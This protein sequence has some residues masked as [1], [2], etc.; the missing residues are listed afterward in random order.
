[1]TIAASTMDIV[2]Q[3]IR[4]LFEMDQPAML[5]GPPGA[6]KTDVIGQLAQAVDAD[7]TTAQLSQ[8]GDVDLRGV[9]HVIEGL[10]HWARPA[11]WP[12]DPNRRHILFLDEFDR[13]HTSVA[14]AALQIILHRRIGEHALPANTYVC[15]AGN[16]STD[17]IGTNKLS[18]ANA[19]RLSHLYCRPSVPAWCD[20]ATGAAIDPVLVAFAR[21]R[22]VDDKGRDLFETA[23]KPLDGEHAFLSPRTLT[24]CAPMLRLPAAQRARLIRG[25][26][27]SA[28]GNELVA[29]ADMVD[30]L[31]SLATVFA[32]PHNAIVPRD[33]SAQWA[34]SGAL[35]RN[36]K[37]GNMAT[38]IIYAERMIRELS[39]AC[40]TMAV[41]TNPENCNTRAYI[42]WSAR[43]QD[44]TI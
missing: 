7:L 3:D 26:I 24:D 30:K 14:N 32:D 6:G 13:A 11:I 4:A 23:A 12:R 1:M 42:E 27:G 37:P 41:R 31:P 44:V 22:S 2:A 25:T 5:W 10:T 43:N 18:S 34:M 29:F 21:F 16:G 8:F 33:L 35:A 20:W 39:V 36:A 28:T 38:V 15:A 9:P 40:V 19:N 17:R